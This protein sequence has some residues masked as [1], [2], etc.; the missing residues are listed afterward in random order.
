MGAWIPRESPELEANK[1]MPMSQPNRLHVAVLRMVTANQ[2]NGSDMN[3]TKAS[4]P[5]EQPAMK[6]AQMVS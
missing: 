6:P 4:G 2:R 1:L 5:S 3:G